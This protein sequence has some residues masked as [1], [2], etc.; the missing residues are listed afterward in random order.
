MEFMGPTW[1]LLLFFSSDV[2]VK[3]H[4]QQPCPRKIMITKGLELSLR[5]VWFKPLGKPPGL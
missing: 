1:T 5:E 3:R 2:I 4:M